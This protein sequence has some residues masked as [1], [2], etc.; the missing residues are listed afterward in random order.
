LIAELTKNVLLQTVFY[1][2]ILPTEL[3][4]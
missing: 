1:L 4:F 3:T 2:A